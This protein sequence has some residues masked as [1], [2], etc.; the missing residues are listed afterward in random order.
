MKLK[1]KNIF[2]FKEKNKNSKNSFKIFEKELTPNNKTIYNFFSKQN[3]DFY[4]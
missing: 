2:P 4:Y 3:S 1:Y